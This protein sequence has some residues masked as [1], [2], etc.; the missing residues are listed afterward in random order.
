MQIGG[1]SK[2]IQLK[3][4][5]CKNPIVEPMWLIID[6]QEERTVAVRSGGRGRRKRGE[7]VEGEFVWTQRVWSLD[8][9]LIK[10]SLWHVSM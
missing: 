4:R 7:S 1:E 3:D 6:T 2:R 5:Q 9:I 8:S 10:G